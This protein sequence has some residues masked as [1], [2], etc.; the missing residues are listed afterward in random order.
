[1]ETHESLEDK[2]QKITLKYTPTLKKDVW[3]DERMIIAFLEEKRIPYE[4]S[5]T[6]SSSLLY[7]LYI[8][9]SYHKK[10]KEEWTMPRI[11]KHFKDFHR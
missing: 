4:L 8:P 9:K 7:A 3:G 2:T 5:P 11:E 10:V 6:L 1:M